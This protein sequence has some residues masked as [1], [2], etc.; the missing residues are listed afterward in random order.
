MEGKAGQWSLG[1]SHKMRCATGLVD[2]VSVTQWFMS[3]NNIVGFSNNTNYTK[4]LNSLTMTLLICQFTF[5]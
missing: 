1:A 3:A 5:F 2:C 4:G